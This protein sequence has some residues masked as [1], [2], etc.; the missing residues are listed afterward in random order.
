MHI[1]I[2]GICG[3]F[4]GGI[5]A[6]AR[7]AGWRVT[8]CDANVYPPM[9]D[10]LAALGIDLVEGFDASQLRLRP[11]LWVVGN[12][13]SRGNPLM[14]AILDAG[15]PYTS[16]PQWL[17]EQVLRSRWVMAVAGT[18]GK[19]TTSSLLAWILEAD[20]RQPGFLIGGLPGNFG[21]SARLGAGE[22]F[23]IEADE[24]DTAF[25]DKRSKFVHYRP[26]TA[27]LNNL[28]FDHADIF[29][30]LAAIET[31]FHH[32][33]R[34]VPGRGRLV[35]NGAQASL[36]RM[37]ARGL[38]SDR[39]DFD[40]DTGW[41]AADVVE[42][43]DAS[44]FTVQRGRQPLGRCRL[45][46]AGA[47]NRSNAVAAI[48]AAAHAGVEPARAIEALGRFEGVRR[49]LEVRG[50]VGGVTVIDDFAHH[51]TAIAT[52][53]AGL[54]ARMGGQGR[55]LA[56]LEPRSNTMKLGTMKAQLPGSLGDAERV[57]CYSGGIG[58]DVGE[59]MAPLGE[60]ALVSDDLDRLVEAIV[61]VAHPGDRVLVMSNGG[62]GGIHQKLLDALAACRR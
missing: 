53:L 61:A 56:V 14:E 30:D 51:P 24:Y 43:P 52:T 17:A 21:V 13:V 46:L 7:E 12:V 39:E 29:P 6:I 8:G 41:H 60:R 4:M 23:V 9:S 47:H 10:Q 44:E 26:R 31:Q 15:Q 35:V 49:R 20:G 45:A 55:I 27:I 38:W 34:T 54:R 11:D 3:T 50:S 58:W 22:W 32:L 37:L 36:A 28:E 33:V 19:T 48:A 57:F 40:T 18:H 2:L 25:F 1:H 59:A 62:F 16:G 42:T 5:A